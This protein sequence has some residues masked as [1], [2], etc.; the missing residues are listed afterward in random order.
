MSKL[1][2][3]IVGISSAAGGLF[4]GLVLALATTP[5]NQEQI[6][7]A[8]AMAL[9]E[10]EF[11]C[12]ELQSQIKD[13]EKKQAKLED[14]RQEAEDRSNELYSRIRSMEIDLGVLED[15]KEL[16]EGE[17]DRHEKAGIEFTS[18]YLKSQALLGLIL[19]EPT[20]LRSLRSDE[21]RRKYRPGWYRPEETLDK[22][23]A[24]WLIEEAAECGIDVEAGPN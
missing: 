2:V 20:V 18:G 16:A 7:E 19:R 12:E 9:I 23:G 24:A 13:L 21:F 14:Q 6:D 22:Y 11:R 5:S 10:P 17:R 4:F 8:V 1:G 3:V 15:E